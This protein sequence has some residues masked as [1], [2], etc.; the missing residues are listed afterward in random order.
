M[1]RIALKGTKTGMRLFRFP[2]NEDRH[3]KWL[4]KCLLEI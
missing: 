2:R 1:L 3:S 4:I